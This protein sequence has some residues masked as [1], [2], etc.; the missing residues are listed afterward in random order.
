MIQAVLNKLFNKVDIKVNGEPDA[1]IY[2]RRWFL[3]PRKPKDLEMVPRRYLHRF[4]TGDS[5]RDLHD[6]PW[7]FDSIIIKGGY[8]EHSFNPAWMRW[9][10]LQKQVNSDED[11]LILAENITDRDSY[12]AKWAAMIR[13]SNAKEPEP[14][15]TIRKWYGPGSFLKRGASWTHA[16]ELKKNKKGENIPCWTIIH[17]GVKCRSW[18]F[19][20]DNGWCWWRNYRSG[21]CVCYDNPNEDEVN[22]IRKTNVS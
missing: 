4:F 10:A 16:V 13:E 14:E 18:G 9:K 17:T 7:P 5:V 1:P 3:Y 8:W 11:K 6:H 15:K 12:E 22:A 2:L 19:H 21:A 20:T